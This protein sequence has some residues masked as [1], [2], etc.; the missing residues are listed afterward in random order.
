MI[1]D[2]EEE[3]FD[4]MPEGL[5]ATEKGERFNENIDSLQN[6]VDRITEAIEELNNAIA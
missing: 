1:K 2:A 6:A 5:Q 4:N 3:A